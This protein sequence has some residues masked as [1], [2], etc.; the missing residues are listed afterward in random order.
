MCRRWVVSCP[1]V[2]VEVMRTEVSGQNKRKK[3]KKKRLKTTCPKLFCLE[4]E[5]DINF[6]PAAISVTR[7]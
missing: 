4:F 6:L 7:Q 3:K 1:Q 2:T 5:G